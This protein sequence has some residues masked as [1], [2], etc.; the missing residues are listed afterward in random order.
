[1]R[2]RPSHLENYVQR[3]CKAHESVTRGV[4]LRWSKRSSYADSEE[5]ARAPFRRLARGGLSSKIYARGPRFYSIIAENMAKFG[6]ELATAKDQVEEAI[7]LPI[8]NGQ[9]SNSQ[10][11]R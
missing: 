7:F 8:N 2:L 4:T 9:S 10:L 11:S 1:M 3:N 6:E 5:R